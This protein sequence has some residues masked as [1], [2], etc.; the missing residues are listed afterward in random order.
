M[1]LPLAYYGAPILRKKS[2]PV[3]AIT[4]EIAQ[5]VNDMLETMREHNGIGLA[6]NQVHKALRLFITEVPIKVSDDPEDHR[7]IEGTVHIFIN[8]TIVER[9]QE[10]WIREEGC[11]SIPKLYGEVERPTTI[12]VRATDLEGNPFEMSFSGL[13]A[14]CIQHEY[15]HID[16]ILYIDRMIPEAREQLEPG[17]REVKKK[18]HL[19]K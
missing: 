15:D 6:A 10:T 17:L 2:K 19:K 4:E 14:R 8:P 11:L 7:W 16:G 5:L 3:E 13:E 1:K 9:S 18:F 12:V